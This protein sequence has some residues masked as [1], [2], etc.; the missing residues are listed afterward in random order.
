[1]FSYNQVCQ[2]LKKGFSKNPP[3]YNIDFEK[4]CNNDDLLHKTEKLYEKW[5]NHDASNIVYEPKTI[6]CCEISEL[7]GND[8]LRVFLDICNNKEYNQIRSLIFF[9]IK[10]HSKTVLVFSKDNLLTKATSP[11]EDDLNV[12]NHHRGMFAKLFND[13]K[14]QSFKGTDFEMFYT[15]DLIQQYRSEAKAQFHQFLS[16]KF[17]QFPF[18]PYGKCFLGLI[19]KCAFRMSDRDPLRDISRIKSDIEL[20]PF[21]ACI[22]FAFQ[23]NRTGVITCLLGEL[24]RLS[25]QDNASFVELGKSVI[26]TSSQI[27]KR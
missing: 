27:I 17:G 4:T 20:I 13:E 5:I 2:E 25:R 23:Q 14:V 7:S 15:T 1:M 8:L 6:G 22:E 21:P 10:G 9:D 3:S 11:S 26:S 18:Y 24:P 12:D 16:E 19:A